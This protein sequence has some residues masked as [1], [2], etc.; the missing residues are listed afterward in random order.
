MK[1]KSLIVLDSNRIL[2]ESRCQQLEARIFE[3]EQTVKLLK[4]RIQANDDLTITNDHKSHVSNTQAHESN[5]Y[6]KMKQ[7][8]NKRI[9][10]MHLKLNNVVIDEMDRQLD[11]IKLKSVINLTVPS[12]LKYRSRQLMSFLS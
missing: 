5:V 1:E 3:L 7:Q 9:A 4:R 12:M 6:G 10:E 11:K 8:I 2:V